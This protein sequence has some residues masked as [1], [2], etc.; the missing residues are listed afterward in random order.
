MGKYLLCLKLPEDLR[1]TVSKAHEYFKSYLVMGDPRNVVDEAR[2]I[3]DRLGISNVWCV[4]DVVCSNFVRFGLTPF[5]CI[6]D[7][8]TLRRE[9]IDVKHLVK[10][11][12]HVI[13]VRNPQ[14]MI[15]DEVFKAVR[16]A[17]KS[18]LIIIEGEE[19]LTGFAVLLA[20]PSNSILAYGVPPNIGVALIPTSKE[21][22]LKA[23]KLLK[24][25]KLTRV[26]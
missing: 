13:R 22:R 23:V 26:D 17:V 1:R 4:G 8:K 12:N 19:D 11:F 6:I 3:V 18:T 9:R 24:M 25:F 20:S 16:R 21:N 5:A 14:G 10:V 2:I 15:C 7:G